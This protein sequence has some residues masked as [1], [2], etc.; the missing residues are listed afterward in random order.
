M[1]QSLIHQFPVLA[2]SNEGHFV[3]AKFIATSQINRHLFNHFWAR[4]H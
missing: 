3:L 2:S 1:I 4:S